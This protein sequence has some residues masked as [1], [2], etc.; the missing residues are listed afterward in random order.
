[1]FWI[2]LPF[3]GGRGR[4]RGARA[5]AAI[6]AEIPDRVPR[7]ASLRR[8]LFVNARVYEL[9]E[10]GSFRRGGICFTDSRKLSTA[11]L[12][13][14]AP[15][16]ERYRDMRKYLIVTMALGALLAVS[17]AG[18]ASTAETVTVGN[19][20]FTADGGFSPKALPKTTL[21]PIALTRRR[22]DQNARRHPPAGAERSPGRNRQE[23]RG[24]RQGLPDLQIGPAAVAG[25]RRTRKRSAR[26][27]SSAKARPTSRSLFPESKPVPV[28]SDTARLQRRRQGRH[29]DASSSTPTSPCRSRP[30]SSPR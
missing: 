24:Q 28:K 1:M 14:G 29:D 21:A 19:L 20:K 25:H 10:V 6:D 11:S 7:S 22:Q 8:S 5:G 2:A 17:V 3:L 16:K 18:I 4:R 12:W 15:Q 9:A 26:K 30:R 23:R 27:R 13:T